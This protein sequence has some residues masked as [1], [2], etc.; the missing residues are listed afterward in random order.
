[1]KDEIY[2]S[3]AKIV[4]EKYVSNREEELYFYS[5]DM[6]CLEPYK[7]SYVVLPKTVEE[8]QQIVKLANKYKIPVVPRGSGLSLTGLVRPL[9]GGIVIDLKRM[10]RIL[11]V[12]E[13][14]RYV[15]IEAGV[16]T[17][18]L[19][20]YL[21]KNY[22][23]L[24]FSMPEAPP[25]ATI[26]GNIVIHGQGRLA[27]QYGFN[28][29]MVNGLEIVL[30]TGE[31]CRIGSCSLSR[32]WFTRAPLPDLIGI[33]LGWLGTTGIITKLSIKLYPNKKLRDIEIFI[34]DDEELVPP[35]ISKVTFTEMAE[36]ILIWGQP[37][38]PI[39]RGFHHISIYITGDTEEELEF[40]RDIIFSSVNE[41][42]KRKVGGFLALTP[43]FKSILTE[44]PQSSATRVADVKRGGGFVYAGPIIP[45]EIYPELY[46]RLIRIAAK[47][48]TTW[49]IFGRIIGR[50]HAVML[51]F[52]I[53]F[54]R[55][56][57][58]DIQKVRKAL[59][60]CDIAALD[61]GGIPWK[62]SIE[63]QKE[64]LKRMDPAARS[65]LLKI[66]N[67]LDPNNIC[68]PGNW[69]VT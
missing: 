3:L 6:G 33:F 8:V 42:I 12:N 37:Y 11:E 15:I 65:L 40:K 58:N 28:S 18:M 39:Y 25:S 55:A 29:D 38:P 61:L 52:I 24:K 43:D 57:I 51:G 54:N 27:Q 31:I 30:P 2:D 23:H 22:P 44:T 5:N 50:G 62:P 7:P 35:V 63:I 47:Y 16:T 21:E 66:K 13:K 41:Y 36:D 56:D 10:N 20:G 46:R 67:M 34:L 49:S 64:I 60:E 17:G 26:V 14:C 45:L 4:G 53:P 9:R 19:K 32:Y 48:E 59:Y 69:E 68:N 1:M